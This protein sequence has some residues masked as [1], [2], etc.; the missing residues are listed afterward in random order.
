MVRQFIPAG[1]RL[2][3]ELLARRRR[4]AAA[5]RRQP[6]HKFPADFQS[7]PQPT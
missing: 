1:V 5:E 3:D 7:Q 4:E 6:R 2:T